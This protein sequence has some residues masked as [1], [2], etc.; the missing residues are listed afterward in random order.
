MG[1]NTRAPAH[2]HIEKYTSRNRMRMASLTSVLLVVAL[3]HSSTACSAGGDSGETTGGLTGGITLPS[4]HVTKG[5]GTIPE[6]STDM[7]RTEN[8]VVPGT[9]VKWTWTGTH[10][11]VEL[12]NATA[13]GAYAACV[14]PAGQ[15]TADETLKH[16]WTAP[17]EE[18]YH[19][20]V[21]GVGRHCVNGM[22]AKIQVAKECD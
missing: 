13:S 20:F 1:L 22:K 16:E 11:V 8:C 18:G 19:Y 21:C 14:I 6:W 5:V 9:K 12:K 4:L 15:T 7:E 17:K 2:R 3:V 10:N